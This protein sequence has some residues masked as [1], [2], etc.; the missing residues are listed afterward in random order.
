MVEGVS[1]NF[2]ARFLKFPKFLPIPAE[3]VALPNDKLKLTKAVKKT[4][5]CSEKRRKLHENWLI[6]G[7]DTPT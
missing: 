7:E 5:S 4:I 1:T 6:N 2:I 3:V